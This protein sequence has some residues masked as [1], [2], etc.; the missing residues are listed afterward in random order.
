VAAQL[1]ER[2]SEQRTDAPEGGSAARWAPGRTGRLVCA[3]CGALVAEHADLFVMSGGS[4]RAVFANPHGRVFEIV[5]LRQAASV[6]AVSAPTTDFSWFSG[7][8]WAI[9]AC[10]G[11]STHLGWSFHAA[12][13]GL[14]PGGFFGLLVDAL[15]EAPDF[16]N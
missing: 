13:P 14:A 4:P 5:T 9:V 1:L 3:R 7:Y 2:D 16:A 11:C 12:A 6:V 10:A 15:A 8:S